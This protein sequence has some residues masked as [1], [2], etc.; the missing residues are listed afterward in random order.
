MGGGWCVNGPT[1]AARAAGQPFWVST[2]LCQVGGEELTVPSFLDMM[3]IGIRAPHNDQAAVATL[4]RRSA[5]L[6]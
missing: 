5:A 2:R 1:C 3:C 6:Q 4:P